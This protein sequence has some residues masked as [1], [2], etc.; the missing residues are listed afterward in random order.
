GLLDGAVQGRQ[1]DAVAD[2]AEQ[3]GDAREQQRRRGREGYIG[4][5]HGERAGAEQRPQ[6]PTP[7]AREHQ[8]PEHGTDA[9]GGQEQAKAAVAYLQGA[10]RVGDLDWRPRLEE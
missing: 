9:P 6:G 4:E 3:G 1:L 5:S 10:L 2:A 8:A 7:R